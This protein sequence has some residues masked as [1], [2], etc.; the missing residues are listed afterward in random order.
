MARVL[1]RRRLELGVSIEDEITHALH[2]RRGADRSERRMRATVAVQAVL[3]RASHVPAALGAGPDREADKL[4]VLKLSG[5]EVDFCIGGFCRRECWS[6]RT[7]LSLLRPKSGARWDGSERQR[8]TNASLRLAN[9]RSDPWC[10]RCE[11]R[12]E[13]DS[14]CDGVRH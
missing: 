3:T 12:A 10:E 1:G 11:S 5:G 6:E 13:A 14:V 2:G 9:A 7:S 4:Q 8:G